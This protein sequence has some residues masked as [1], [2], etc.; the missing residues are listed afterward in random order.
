M[1][2]ECLRDAQLPLMLEN[3]RE[4][5]LARSEN[6]LSIVTTAQ[7]S[8]SEAYLDMKVGPKSISLNSGPKSET[9][10]EEY[11]GMENSSHQVLQDYYE[12]F[13]PKTAAIKAIE[14]SIER[15]N[16]REES[17]TL[18]KI[19]KNL[20][21]TQSRGKCHK[22][23]PLYKKE[24]R[25]LFLSENRACWAVLL[26]T[27]LL[28]YRSERHNRPYAVYP[29][30]GYMAR[31]APNLIPRDRQKSESAF[32]MYC[33]GSETLQFIARTRKEMNQ[34]IAKVHEVG[35]GDESKTDSNMKINEKDKVGK[36][37]LTYKREENDGRRRGGGK[38]PV[39]K[40]KL[41]T[42]TESKA[43]SKSEVERKDTVAGSPPPLP[44]R[45]PLRFPSSPSSCNST[46]P[47]CE[48]AVADEDD[49]DEIY[50]KIED[51]KTPYQNMMLSRKRRTSL[52]RDDADGYD[53]VSKETKEE[54]SVQQERD[55][56]SSLEET[57]DDI[58]TRVDAVASVEEKNRND[59]RAPIA[60]YEETLY[61]DI[62]V[63]LAR[64]FLYVHFR[65][66]IIV[67][68]LYS[69]NIL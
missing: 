6:I 28:I 35:C 34:W 41:T 30:R 8:S 54:G 18:I 15:N 36:K 39:A 5:L 17:Q 1:F 60:S 50:Y 11:V 55:D 46:A 31:P 29:I 57:Y 14:P 26:G 47:P 43:G 62:D 4:K 19:Y 38:S 56:P 59:D 16:D 23:G 67:L 65:T 49:D 3:L 7:S 63:S 20:S 51:L 58:S 68:Q 69:Y 37:A 10:S 42:G 40:S 61:D 52:K 9:D 24:S 13:E 64:A 32:E 44:A 48:T 25:K 66:E 2:L 53:D 22:Y 45:I 27:H 33:P 12:I 21:A